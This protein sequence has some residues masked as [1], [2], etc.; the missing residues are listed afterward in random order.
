[1]LKIISVIIA[2]LLLSVVPEL[3]DGNPKCSDIGFAY[4]LSA[5]DGSGIYTDGDWTVELWITS[6]TTDTVT[7]ESNIPVAAAIIK[8]ATQANIYRFPVPVL[9]ANDLSSPNQSD[10]SH[11]FFCYGTATAV[12]VSG[13]GVR[14]EEEYNEIYWETASELTTALYE[15]TRNGV[16]IAQ[17]P[18]QEPGSAIGTTYYVIDA[19][20][21]ASYGLRAIEIDGNVTTFGPE[22]SCPTPVHITFLSAVTGIFG[23]I[24]G[25]ALC[26]AFLLAR[27]RRNW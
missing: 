11:V 1:M 21:C 23:T 6:G 27:R 4:Q 18:P 20:G 8:A 15:V 25:V 17:V 24:A 5:E 2:V 19:A 22:S 16:V 12:S 9:D 26:L 7:F 13:F 10:V 14:H 3:V